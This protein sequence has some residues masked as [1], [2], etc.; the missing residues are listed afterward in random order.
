M[1]QEVSNYPAPLDKLIP[2]QQANEVSKI[3][4]FVKSKHNSRSLSQDQF[5]LVLDW[6]KH[7]IF[8]RGTNDG[9]VT[10]LYGLLLSKSTTGSSD[11]RVI[12]SINSAHELGAAM[13]IASTLQF[14]V[15]RSKC[16]DKT[17]DIQEAKDLLQ[18]LSMHS[19]PFFNR[20]SDKKK[21]EVLQFALNLEN[22]A[23]LLPDTNWICEGGMRSINKAIQ[24]GEPIEEIESNGSLK[25]SFK[26]K[27][28]RPEI[29]AKE[30]WLKAR[31]QIITKI[32]S[33][34]NS[35][36]FDLAL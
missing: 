17:G 30:D 36:K 25:K 35:G 15:A 3:V 18:G 14:R 19:L 28:N 24:N 1:A 27:V 7:W 29:L 9:R 20:Q 16:K 21:A 33:E 22:R 23:H 2:L 31:K 32:S 10:A 34:I 5:N 13:M 8:T 6:L 12:E 26:I 11:P 4:Q